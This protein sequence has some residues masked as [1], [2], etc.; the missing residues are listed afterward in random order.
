MNLQASQGEGAN[1]NEPVI[2]VGNTKDYEQVET[3]KR[4]GCDIR[5]SLTNKFK[6]K[7][8]A[9]VECG[10][11]QIDVAEKYHVNRS[12]LSKWTKH[13]DKITRAAVDENKKMFT[14]IRPSAKYNEMFWVLREQFLKARSQGR[15][16]DFNWL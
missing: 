3:E 5:K 1:A 16:V 9:E 12:Q 11:K 10:M 4:R 6:S 2:A 8:I 7:T 13:K 15:R 14:K